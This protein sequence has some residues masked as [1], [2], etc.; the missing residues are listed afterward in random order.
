MK[1]KICGLK[2]LED[3]E[4][5]NQASIDYAGFIFAPSKRQI[6]AEFAKELKNALN[7]NITA[8][9]VFVNESYEFVK[10]LIDE[11]II[12]VAQ[13]HGDV[14]YPVPIPSIR[15]FSMRGKEDI[16]STNCDFVLFDLPKNGT[17]S[18]AG[19]VFDWRLI[20]GYS[21][22]PFFLAGGINATNIRQAMELNPYC[23]DIAGGAEDENGNKSLLKIMELKEMLNYD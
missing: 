23:I 2:R 18:S 3:V 10:H 11:Q 20:D 6:T 15:A 14:E 22:K 1:L 4:Y 9:G 13:F 17:R 8:V 5:V 12:D 7:P 16:K 19:G 21:K